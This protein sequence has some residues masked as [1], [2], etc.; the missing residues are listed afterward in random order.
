LLRLIGNSDLP[1]PATQLRQRQGDD[2]EHRVVEW[3]PR[4][5][6]HIP[7]LGELDPGL[8]DVTAALAQHLRHRVADPR[9]LLRMRVVDEQH[10]RWSHNRNPPYALTTTKLN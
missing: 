1:G 4:K 5:P 9:G 6:L 7:R 2:V 3:E 10:L 8:R